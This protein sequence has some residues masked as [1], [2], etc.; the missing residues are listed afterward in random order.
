MLYMDTIYCEIT[1]CH[2]PKYNNSTDYCANHRRAFR[3]YGDPLFTKV[4]KVSGSTPIRKHELYSTWRGMKNR[5]LNKNSWDYKYYGGRGIKVCNRWKDSF[6]NFLEDM[7][8][9]PYPHYTLDRINPD[10]NY[11]PGNCRWVSM[12]DQ[13][14]N[15]PSRGRSNTVGVHYVTRSKKWV[16][17]LVFNKE[18]FH[19]SEHDNELDAIEA[20]RIAQLRVTSEIKL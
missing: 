19:K 6:V 10:G 1:D 8:E 5:V 14:L 20:R 11:E 7:G 16:A 15:K 18:V 13:S 2:L 9:K 12:Y 17:R 4:R 3:L